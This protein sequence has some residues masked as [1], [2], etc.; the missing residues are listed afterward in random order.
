MFKLSALCFASLVALQAPAAFAQD[1]ARPASEQ[2]LAS[3]IDAAIAPYYKAD[4][5]G[6][7]VIVTQ[8]G[9]TVLRK[10]YGMADVAKGKA[11]TPDTALRLGSITKQF[12]AV[13]ILMLLDEGK[14]ALDDDITKFLPDYPTRGKRIT[15]EHLLTHTSGIVS[16][17]SRAGFERNSTNDMSVSGMIDTFKNDPLDFDPG[18]RFSYNNSG[19]FL[20]GAVIEK[21]SGQPYAKFVEERIFKPLDMQHTAY[22]GHERNPGPRAAGHTKGWFG[23]TSSKPLSMSQ[24]YAA[25]SLVS[26]VDDLARWDAA[27]TAGKLLKPATWQKATTS[28]VLADGKPT[29]YG[30]GWQIGKLRGVPMVSHGGGINGFSTY[31]LRL[32]QQ[33]VY[34]AVLTNSDDAKIQPEMVASKAAAI[35]IG[36]PFPDFKAVKID[37]ALLDAY[38]GTYRIDA[39]ATR[40]FKRDNGKLVMQRSNR[41]PITLTPYANDGFFMPDSLT[42]IVFARN[43]KGEVSHVVVHS[44]G[45]ELI[46]QRVDTP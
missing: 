18:T 40:S 22:E 15:I 39:N 17:T 32:P 19:Y 33:K 27:I 10:A 43:A 2:A 38:A 28:Y 30:Y 35:A 34:V 16:Y 41:E 9:K 3:R 6:A 12:T 7:T 21:I 45:S 13:G 4:A 5:P 46:N 23:V 25:G 26:T 42:T 31:A 1:A 29:N 24:P 14:L 11:M 44:Q 8:D 37:D 20:L 36:N